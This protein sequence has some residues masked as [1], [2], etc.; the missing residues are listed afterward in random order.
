MGWSGSIRFAWVNFGA[1][2]VQSDSR[3]FAGSFPRGWR[4]LRVRTASCCRWVD[5]DS[6]GF[7]RT[8]SSCSFGFA[9]GYL[10]ALKCHWVHSGSRGFTR[11]CLGV[12]RFIRVRLGSLGRAKGTPGSFGFA[13]IHCALLSVA[14]FT[15]VRVS[16]L[17]RTYRSS[18]SFGFAWVHSGAPTGR[19]VDHVSRGFTRAR[20]VVVR[21]ILDC[22]G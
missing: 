3:G 14:K 15:R 9:C 10:G 16:S 6:F 2:R 19:R 12:V 8:G 18:G 11:A 13:W 21:F 22:L 20:H 1:R 17:V 7:T 4:V 5:S